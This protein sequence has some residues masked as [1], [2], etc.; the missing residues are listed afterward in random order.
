MN[1]FRWVKRLNETCN[2][3]GQLVEQEI[4][5]FESKIE[6]LESKIYRYEDKLL[7]LEG[8]LNDKTK[9]LEDN[10]T[11][12]L[13]N[14]NDELEKELR[15]QKM[16]IN[17]KIREIEVQ[18]QAKDT[19]IEQLESKMK[20]ETKLFH[21]KIGAIQCEKSD[22]NNIANEALKE[23]IEC[24]KHKVNTN[25]NKLVALIDESNDVAYKNK[26]K[27]ESRFKCDYC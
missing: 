20:E 15:N 22:E 19:E 5:N 7:M 13:T 8:K 4:G 3:I 9:G 18:L 10:L 17:I 26:K 21:E 1:L 23:E 6:R 24:I 14:N 12:K 16:D 25:E 11:A 2:D 27:L